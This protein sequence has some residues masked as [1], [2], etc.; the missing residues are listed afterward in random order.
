MKKKILVVDDEPNTRKLLFDTLS[1]KGYSIT[2]AAN[3]EEAIGIT[4]QER[5]DLILLD[6]LMP[7]LNGIETLKIIRSF[8]TRTKIIM[9]TVMDQTILERQARLNGASGFLRKPADLPIIPKLVEQILEAAAGELKK[10]KVLIVDDDPQTCVLLKDF[11]SWRGFEPL[12]AGTAEEALEKVEKE[13][14]RIVLLDIKLPGM[15]GLTALRKIKEANKDMDIVMI[16][17]VEDGSVASEAIKSGAYDYV[18]KPLN[19]DY[20]ETCLLIKTLH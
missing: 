13:K 19:L 10:E 5:F 8:D 2:T 18:I 16:T 14:P 20:L 17:G 12:V 1:L 7:G 3:G 11:L 9:L 15:D 6:I 4:K